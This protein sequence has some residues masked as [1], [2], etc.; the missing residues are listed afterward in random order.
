MPNN[1]MTLLSNLASGFVPQQDKEQP[2]NKIGDTIVGEAV[3]E[4]TEGMHAVYNV[5]QNQAKHYKKPIEKIAEE[6]YS[7]YKRKDLGAFVSKQPKD[8]V[9]FAHG[10]TTKEQQDITNGA[11]HFENI[12][13]YG[14]PK[15]A[16]DEGGIIP[17]AKIGNHTFFLT[18]KE[19][20]EREKP[21]RE[22]L[23]P[24]F[25]ILEFNQ[26]QK[27]LPIDKIKVEPALVEKLEILRTL[28]GNRAI[29]ITS[30]YRSPS[31]NKLINGAKNSQHQYGRAADI[32]VKGMTSKQLEPYAKK[33]GFKYIQ[34]Y[35]DKPHLHVD[36]RES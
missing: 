23:S 28:I 22:K 27:P 20:T 32:M 10:L 1:L 14:I 13:K 5:M 2:E 33:A 26:P 34:T 18:K 25:D 21:P 36:V 16:K 4:G 7:A 12:E 29:K 3:D 6:K 24:N 9:Q 17:T 30:G 11:L 31:Y 35:P 19:W 15:Y 8:M